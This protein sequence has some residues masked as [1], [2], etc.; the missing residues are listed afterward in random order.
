MATVQPG[1]WATLVAVAAALAASRLV[2]GCLDNTCAGDAADGA[3]DA[4]SALDDGGAGA[5]D[6]GTLS[7]GSFNVPLSQAVPIPLTGCAGP[8][9]AAEF[10]VGAQTFLL[11]IDTGS[12]TLALAST[13]C[14]DCNV[15]PTYSPNPSAEAGAKVGDTYVHGSWQGQ[16][17]SDSVQ[18][19]GTKTPPVTMKIAAINSQAGFFLD[20]GCD[21]GTVTFA[22]QGI[23]G[24]GPSDLV[25]AGTDD[26]VTKVGAPLDVFAVELCPLGGQLMVG[27]VN[28]M[29]A[30]LTGPASYTPMTSSIYYGIAIDDMQLAGVSLGFGS[31]AFGT[32]AVDT[33]TSFLAL[34]SPIFVALVDKIEALPAFSTAFGGNTTWLGTTTCLTSTLGPAALDMQLP[35]LTIQLPAV[36]GGTFPLTLKATQSYIPP[37]TS[38]GTIYYCSGVFKNPSTTGTIFGTSA[39][40]GQMAIFDLAKNQ[41]GFAP[42]TF[43][44]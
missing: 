26:F 6:A 18:I 24:F 33:G 13:A 17:Y 25:V 32:A 37:T 28:P 38:N 29:A 2:V 39:M 19:V 14:T 15:T 44:P 20:A 10:N 36:G 43:C 41:I 40:L 21:M 8:G 22:P 34:P 5:N 27:G 11:T 16:V 4:D 12:G 7:D 42:Q 35:A 9:Y 1:A 23:V 30:A 3:A 31:Q